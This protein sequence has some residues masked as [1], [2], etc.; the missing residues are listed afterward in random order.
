[1]SGRTRDTKSFAGAVDR[2]RWTALFGAGLLLA[3]PGG[4][5]PATRAPVAVKVDVTRIAPLADRRE[6]V[7]NVRAVDRVEIRARVRGY[8][9]AQLFEDGAHVEKGALLFK[10]DPLPFEVA[11]AESKGQLARARADAIRAAN[12]LERADALF[13][14]GVV[15]RELIDERRAARDET[16]AAVEAAEA[17]VKAAEL[18][19]SYGTIR[20]PVAGRIGRA[21]IDVG[22]LVGESNQDTILA[23][24][25]LEDPV[26][27]YFTVPEGEAIPRTVARSGPDAAGDAPAIPVRIVLGDGARYSHAGVVDYVEPTVDAARGTLSL[28]ARVPNPEGVLRPGQ[29]VRVIAEFPDVPRAVLVAQRAVL[30]EQGG[31]YVLLVGANDIVE[32]RPVRPGR[33]V[34][35]R[36][37]ILEGLAAGE[38]VIVDGVQSV[39]PGDVVR[40]EPADSAPTTAEGEVGRKS[41]AEPTAKTSG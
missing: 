7:G 41:H 37:E 13:K 23:E 1:M 10:I 14:D 25:V 38:R 21:L 5:A 27:V 16:A 39:R 19:L 34:E 20:A 12:D 2:L 18:D 11:L 33:A 17:T 36:Q 15:S 9:V 28:R 22:N 8:L 35:G 24:L 6:Y 26:H 32:R 40:A 3:C 29:F 4:E 31:S 30:D